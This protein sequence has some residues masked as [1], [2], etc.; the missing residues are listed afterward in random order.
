MQFM[1]TILQSAASDAAH[2]WS[3]EADA[4]P[5]CTR[6]RHAS[7]ARAASCSLQ[8]ASCSSQLKAT[9]PRQQCMVGLW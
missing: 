2:I 8:I 3:M 7:E 1:F 4:P 6:K 9:L 5:A